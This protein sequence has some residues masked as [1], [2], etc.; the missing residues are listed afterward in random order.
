[1]SPAMSKKKLR[2]LIEGSLEKRV[3]RAQ[4]RGRSACADEID[5]IKLECLEMIS[6]I[7]AQKLAPAEKNV[8]VAK[9]ASMLTALKECLLKHA[10]SPENMAK[11]WTDHPHAPQG[12]FLV[13]DPSDELAKVC[14]MFNLRFSDPLF[15]ANSRSFFLLET[16]HYDGFGE[17]PKP[18]PTPNQ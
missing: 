5:A 3:R 11:I 14:D 1:M 7:S 6:H 12:T 2:K 13:T 18:Q 17:A 16:G 4:K 10:D 15:E 8:D 9:M